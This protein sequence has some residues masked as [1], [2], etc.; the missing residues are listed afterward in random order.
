M[1]NQKDEETDTVVQPD[2][3]IVC[4]KSKLDDKGSKGA[5]D[6]IVE[7]I[8]PSSSQRDLKDKFYLYE[9]FG[10]KEYWIVD[11]IG[12]TAMVFKLGEKGEYGKPDMYAAA[13]KIK[14]GI[15]EDL[16]IDLNTV[17]AE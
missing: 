9:K 1:Q 8:S 10:V 13:D 7:I 5:P 3:L 14:V 17:F 4:D 16:E 2:I 11:P 12:K 15:F 6:L